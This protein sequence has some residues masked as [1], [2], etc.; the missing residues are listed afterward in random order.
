[1]AVDRWGVFVFD[2]D[3]DM[4][5]GVFVGPMSEARADEKEQQLRRAIERA[6]ENFECL[7]VP[8]EPGSKG[9]GAIVEMV[10]SRGG[11]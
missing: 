2:A 11:G 6:G 5:A 9:A 8:V 7:T 1:M 10:R 4:G 3:G